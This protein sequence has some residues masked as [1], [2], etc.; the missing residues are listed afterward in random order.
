MTAPQPFETIE[1]VRADGVVE[2]TLAR[3]HR[4][5]ALDGTMRDELM[6]VLD[7]LAPSSEDRVLVVPGA[8]GDF[9]SGADLVDG[10]ADSRH[11]LARMRRINQVCL[12]LHR[13]PPPTIAKVRG[14]AVGA[15]MNLALGCD[16]VVAAEDAR[17]SQ[18][19]ARRGLSV[20]FG[21][22]WFLPRR[23]GLHR[24]KELALLAEIIDAA[25][26]AELGVVN[27]V[28]PATELDAFVAD[29]AGRLST[30]PPIALSLTKAMLDNAFEVTL[31]QAL[32]DEA[33]AQTVNFATDDTTEAFAA[34][35]EKRTP[36][37]RGR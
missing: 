22:S 9:C 31:E 24:A 13:L 32:E 4:K 25:T 21:G 19:F 10:A 34:F 23:I 36:S 26:A 37:F 12:A 35:V 2:L 7:E 33:R 11:G 6:V 28:V 18:I 30:G 20:D 15:G 29:W 1:V 17:F 8:G 3:P 14:V 16:L 5:N 27:R